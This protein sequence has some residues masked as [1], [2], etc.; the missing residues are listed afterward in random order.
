MKSFS[1]FV[2]VAALSFLAGVSLMYIAPRLS[3]TSDMANQPSIKPQERP[4]LPPPESV[5]ADLSTTRLVQPQST[6]EPTSSPGE[7]SSHAHS[8][9]AAPQAHAETGQGPGESQ[10]HTH[11]ADVGQPHDVGPGSQQHPMHEPSAGHTHASA[12]T[13]QDP[14]GD[15]HHHGTEPSHG[16]ESD[17]GHDHQEEAADHHQGDQQDH[18]HGSGAGHSHEERAE[19][20]LPDH[21]STVGE[22]HHHDAENGHE[23]AHAHGHGMTHGPELRNPIPSTTASV[24]RGQQLFEIYCRVCHGPEGKGGMPIAKK[25]PKIPRYT[26][27]L[28]RQV[29]DSHL[30]SMLTS[31]HGPMP[32]YGEALSA[33]ERWH[34]INYLRTLQEK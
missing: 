18:P 11:G 28:L 5:P 4:F 30:Y 23:H 26:P 25:Y 16:H 27:D 24:K 20:R 32:G 22:T 8:P 34:T 6:T 19:S 12:D 17:M 31:G 29:S 10:A 1:A 33:E 21:P 13:H 9:E 15:G 2:V 14:Q 3:W 7:T